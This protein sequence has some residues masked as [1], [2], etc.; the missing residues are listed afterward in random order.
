MTNPPAPDPSLRDA[1]TA[2]Y[3]ARVENRGGTSGRVLVR[4][5]GSVELGSPEPG[6]SAETILPT[7][8]PRPTASGFNPEQFLAMAWSTCLGETLRVVLAEHGLDRE[9]SVDVEVELHRDPAGGF[10]FVPRALVHIDSLGPDRARELAAAAHA[11]CPVSKLLDGQ[12][13][14]EVQLVVEH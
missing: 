12:V 3:T 9:S 14:A 6:A 1:G 11:R 4:D 2:L 8:G 5:A 7:G 13:A 10:R